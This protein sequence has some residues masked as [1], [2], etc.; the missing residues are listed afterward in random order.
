MPTAYAGQTYSYVCYVIGTEKKVKFNTCMREMSDI[1]S[2]LD[3]SIITVI[4]CD[5]LILIAEIQLFENTKF[6]KH[7]PRCR[8]LILFYG[9][10]T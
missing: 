1:L 5:M 8:Q 7:N 6:S 3:E 4:E 2:S 9:L 10:F